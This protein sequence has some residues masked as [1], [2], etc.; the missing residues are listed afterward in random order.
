MTGRQDRTWRLLGRSVPRRRGLLKHPDLLLL[1]RH[2]VAQL[3]L[4]SNQRLIG[5][6]W[7]DPWLSQVQERTDSRVIDLLTGRD[8]KAAADWK[9]SQRGPGTGR[10]DLTPGIRGGPFLL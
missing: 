2:G 9:L 10:R 4:R 5:D 3:Q 8:A 6:S 7:V 1:E